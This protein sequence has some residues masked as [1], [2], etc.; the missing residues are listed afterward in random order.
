MMRGTV[1]WIRHKQHFVAME[2]TVEDRLAYPNYDLD[3]LMFGNN[4][5]S[6]REQ[7]AAFMRAEPASPWTAAVKKLFQ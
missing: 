2:Y 7:I 6:C 4:V 3:K 5:Q 1:P